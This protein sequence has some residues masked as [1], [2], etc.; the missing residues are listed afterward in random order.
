MKQREPVS[1]IMTTEVL[2][3]DRE[4]GT[5]KEAQTMMEKNRIRH[6]PV[7]SGSKIEGIISLTDIKRISYG[8]NFGQE[9]D[10]DAAI[11]DMLDLSQVM[12]HHPQTVSKETPIKEVAEML[13]VEE[14]H[15]LP[16]ADDTGNLEGIV[17]STDLIKFLLE[18]Y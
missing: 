16:V 1:H 11:F 8:G 13:A 6:L 2:T 15:A 12:V 4:G 17:T 5:L 3:I 18:Q 10:V 7:V 14:Y 9:G